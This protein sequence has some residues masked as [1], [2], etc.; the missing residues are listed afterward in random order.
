[1]RKTNNQRKSFKALQSVCQAAA[2]VCDEELA[3]PEYRSAQP[4]GEKETFSFLEVKK[5]GR[6]KDVLMLESGEVVRAKPG[7]LY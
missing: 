3:A 6:W 5:N 7:L 1:M 2:R 4:K